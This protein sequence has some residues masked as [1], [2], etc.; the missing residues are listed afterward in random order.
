MRV[1]LLSP[2]FL[3]ACAA[4]AAV[5]IATAVAV[6]K[7]EMALPLVFGIAALALLAY[8]PRKI[9][10]FAVL[11]LPFQNAPALTGDLFGI[12]GAKLL[13]IVLG[14]TLVISFLDRPPGRHYDMI[15][16]RAM[17]VLTVYLGVF[18]IEFFRSVGNLQLFATL[19][20]ELFHA[21]VLRYALSF[22][23]KPVLFV[24]PFIFILRNMA[25]ESDRVATIVSVAIF[26]LSA[27]VMLAVLQDPAVLGKGRHAMSALTIKVLGMHYNLVGT[28]YITVGPLLVY[29][30]VS[31]GLFAKVNLAL[32]FTVLLVIQSRSALIAF[33]LAVIITL[34]VL[35]RTLVLIAA[36]VA[37]AVLLAIWQGPTTAALLSIGVNEGSS[38]GVS[39]DGLFTGR[40]D[41]VWIPLLQEWFSDPSLL[42]FGAGRYAILTT[43]LWL[44]G[45]IYQT[46]HAHNAFVDFFIDSGIVLTLGLIAGLIAW[47]RWTWRIGRAMQSPFF[48]ALFMCPVAYLMGTLTE[49]QFYPAVDN[50]MLFPILALMLNT[51]RVW[52]AEMAAEA[53]VEAEAEANPLVATG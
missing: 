49:R 18:A 47:L 25:G 9:I 5:A 50:M 11:L 22:F 14:A 6:L 21:D 37:G 53:E 15:E 8:D 28:I 26:L 24:V 4:A 32:A 2:G 36:T 35:R 45:D 43:P 10:Y 23:V 20:P 29:L 16:R 52:A 13:N 1:S 33:T 3:F 40:I 27:A 7:P 41:S 39:L 46:T 17:I 31:R 48:W 19:M 12:P 38:S 42:V 30:A 51:I 34:I 44:Y